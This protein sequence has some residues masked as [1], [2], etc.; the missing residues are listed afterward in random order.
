MS[1]TSH[2]MNTLLI[3]SGNSSLKWALYH[4]GRLEPG[5][6]VIL[7]HPHQAPLLSTQL[8]AVWSS[9]MEMNHSLDRIMI[10]NVS[11]QWVMDALYHWLGDYLKQAS[12]VKDAEGV[13]IDNV[14]AEGSA[15]G[16]QNAYEEPS[17]LG[18]DRWAGLIAAR[19][20]VPGNSCIIDCGSAL[21][22]DVLSKA[23]EHMGGTI[24]PGWEMMKKSLVRGADAILD[25]IVN[26][27]Q[28]GSSLLGK[29]TRDAVEAGIAAAAAGAV[30]HVIQRYQKETGLQLQC[31]ITG[32]GAQKLLPKLLLQN[33]EGVFQ[34]EPDWVL[35]G[36]AIIADGTVN[37]GLSDGRKVK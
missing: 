10:S 6:P 4:Q 7:Q 11:G 9:L 28:S 18:A 5:K 1:A 22:I 31:V 36:L 30:N 13:T 8:S 24:T 16:V 17:L 37:K 32:G 19:Q 20:L 3:D 29:N 35:K 33:P 12:S 26:G 14:I 2:S 15:F 27:E 34:H 21:T 23:G 25:E